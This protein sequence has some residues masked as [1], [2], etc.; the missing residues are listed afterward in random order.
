MIK[1]S[2]VVSIMPKNTWLTQYVTYCASQT[3]SPLAYHLGVGL[4]VMA[5]SCPT[6]YTMRFFG[7]MPTNMYT[8]LAGRSGEDQKSTALNLGEEILDKANYE[9]IGDRLR[10]L[11]IVFQNKISNAY[12]IQSLGSSYHKQKVDTWKV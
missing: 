4:T 3:T 8:L 12:C 1:E 2:Q 10:G 7:M 5:M 6:E 9:L 11:S